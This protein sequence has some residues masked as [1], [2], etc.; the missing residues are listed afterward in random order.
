MALPNSGDTVPNVY[1]YQQ[2]LY[3]PVGQVLAVTAIS[4]VTQGAPATFGTDPA[5]GNPTITVN[6]VTTVMTAEGAE[7]SPTA[8]TYSDGT[9][10]YVVSNGPIS[11][12]VAEVTVPLLNLTILAG[13]LGD[14]GLTTGATDYVACY[15]AGT[16]ILT[17]R[18]ETP[19]EHLAIGDRLITASGAAR[20][21]RWIGTRSYASRFLGRDTMPVC[22]KR[23]AL[24]DGVP[25]RDLY[26]SPRHAVFIDGALFPAG[27]LVNGVSIVT[28]TGLDTV[29][30]F[31]L[32]L[33]SHDVILA[34][35]AAA[36]SF[37]DDNSRAMF[38][39]AD[40]Y[41]ALYPAAKTVP[42]Q[43][44]APR[45]EDGY[46]LEHMIQHLAARGHLLGP[47]GI[48]RPLGQLI[49]CFDR[50]TPSLIVGW[51]RDGDAPDRPVTLSI[52]DNGTV[53]DEAVADQYRPDLKAAGIGTGC[54]G[55]AVPIPGRL[56]AQSDH[57]ISVRRKADGAEL[58]GSPLTLAAL[59]QRQAA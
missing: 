51:A 29:H 19:V 38:Q 58:R 49:G 7:Q 40:D 18:G 43:Y 46:R 13:G 50:L 24:D 56:L 41:R 23:G 54:H 35:G 47:D 12:N 1:V 32:E 53:I 9:N 36:E 30:Y 45:I 21:L 33:G 3:V 48:A 5:T 4:P 25:H 39:N 31:H 57:V 15:L 59:D 44:C 17:D 22:I 20:P 2:S 8:F 27:L 52:L 55:F 6:G 42:A 28:A 34:E 14:I 16:M 37:V 26:V 10:T 11:T